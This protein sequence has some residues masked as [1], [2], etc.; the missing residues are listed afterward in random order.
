MPI[1]KS[2]LAASG[3]AAKLPAGPMMGP[4]AGPTLQIAVAAP[5]TA[6]M[7]SSPSA[8]SAAARIACSLGQARS[9]NRVVRASPTD[10]LTRNVKTANQ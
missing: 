4:S 6:V 9:F 3:R 8:P 10:G 5:E 1:A 2:H 7:K